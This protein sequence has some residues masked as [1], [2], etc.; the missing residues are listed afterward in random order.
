MENN[1]GTNIILELVRRLTNVFVLLMFVIVV[2]VVTLQ[3]IMR[4]CFHSSLPWATELSQY[5]FVWL[6]YIGGTITIRRAMNVSFDLLLDHL[7][8]KVWR[9]AK[10]FVGLL[11]MCFLGLMTWLGVLV[12]KASVG[13]LTPI[14]QWKM[15]YITLAI[16]IGGTLMFFEE[17][18]FLIVHWND[19]KADQDI[20]TSADTALEVAE[21]KGGTK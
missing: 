10:L 14:L 2:V 7:P 3:V 12:C 20:D 19:K 16:P 11:T 4:F 17:I 15:H 18:S 8:E 9:M 13:E 5:A 1:K 6:V 21:S